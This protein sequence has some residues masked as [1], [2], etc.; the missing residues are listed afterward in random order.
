MKLDRTFDE[1]RP[2]T[3]RDELLSI[4][5]AGYDG[6]VFGE[7]AFEPLVPLAAAT[8]HTKTVDLL[9]GVLVAFPRSPTHV[10]YA[11]NDLQRLSDGRFILGLGSQVKAHVERRFG[12]TWS[13][14]AARMRE[15]ILAV[16]AVFE[17]WRADSSLSF[18]GDFYDLSL[19]TPYFTPIM[20]EYRDPPIWLAAVG[21]RMCKVA[22]EV[23]DGLFVHPFMSVDSLRQV[24][25]WAD[26]DDN[27]RSTELGVAMPIMIG[28]GASNGELAHAVEKVRYQIAWYGS[29]P[30]YRGVLE[31]HGWGDL[32]R[33]LHLLSKQERWTEMSALID[34]E[35]LSTFSLVGSPERVGTDITRRFKGLLTRAIVYTPG[36]RLTSESSARLATTFHEAMST[37]DD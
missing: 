4:E 2:E 34:D 17:A 7:G 19:M 29:T 10:A 24:R 28:V 15:Y 27:E 22:G 26:P 8:Q 33:D 13:R 11:A 12:S 3:L 23:A 1:Y 16:R 6:V 31:L 18:H 25:G 21:P 37:R 5:S 36:Y 9:T 20:G 32:A 14:P 30:A 35:V